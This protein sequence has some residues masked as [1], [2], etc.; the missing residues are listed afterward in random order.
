MAMKE[1]TK[2]FYILN[3]RAGKKERDEEK[4]SRYIN[5]LRYEIQDKINMIKVR[6]VEDS[7]QIVMKKEKWA[8]KQSQQSRGS[9]LSKSKGISHDKAHKPKG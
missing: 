3:I 8:R 6:T 4:F 9:S 2:D 5:D 1:Y 7:Y